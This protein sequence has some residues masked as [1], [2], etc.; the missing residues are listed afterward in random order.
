M[1]DRLSKFLPEKRRGNFLAFTFLQLLL[2]PGILSFLGISWGIFSGFTL[3]AIITTWLFFH[4]WDWIIKNLWFRKSNLAFKQLIPDL[5]DALLICSY[6]DTSKSERIE[7]GRD[8]PKIVVLLSR[9][10]TMYIGLSQQDE[11]AK[12]LGTKETKKI[13]QAHLLQTLE[14]AENQRYKEY[15]ELL[16]KRNKDFAEKLKDPDYIKELAA[17]PKYEDLKKFL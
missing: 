11:L 9:L 7:P 13:I 10:R 8:Y 5:K 3:A 14:Y 17:H 2:W 16:K 6:I 15:V 1:I 4:N 12:Y